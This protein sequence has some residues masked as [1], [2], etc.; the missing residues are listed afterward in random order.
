MK[1]GLK[2]FI[3][4]WSGL[5]FMHGFFMSIALLGT[6]YGSDV[7]ILIGILRS[8]SLIMVWLALV[9]I[10]KQLYSENSGA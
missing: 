1:K 2:I 5:I 6:V 3:Y 10:Y 9:T 7:L 4:I 8:L